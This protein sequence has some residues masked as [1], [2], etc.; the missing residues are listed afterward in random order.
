MMNNSLA[1][2]IRTKKLGVLLRNARLYS[3][4]SVEE[5]A[6]ALSVP[7][8][9]FEQFEMGQQAPSLP[10]L[11]ILAQ[12][13][14]IPLEHFWGHKTLSKDGEKTRRYGPDQLIK[15]RQRMVG[16]QVRQARLQSGLSIEELAQNAGLW[17][18]DLQKYEMGDEPIPMPVLE[19]LA[20]VLQ[21]SPKDFQDKHGPFGAWTT[22]QAAIQGLLEMPPELQ[23]FVS[24]PINRP[25][26]EL[27]QRLSEMSVERLRAVA[28]GLL[29]ITL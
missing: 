11:E 21:H 22:Q 29:E 3:H 12:Y 5:C 15:L 23:E 6:Q 16:V 10:E 14:N 2:S 17:A 4:K 8:Q 25:Y 13:L 1:L 20:D 7:P 26:L 24:K 28:E 9:R 27:A 19:I 18:E